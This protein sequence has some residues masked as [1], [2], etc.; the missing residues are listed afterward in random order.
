MKTTL[1][2]LLIA[3]IGLPAYS[4]TTVTTN[5]LD[6]RMPEI[7]YKR[8][9]AAPGMGGYFDSPKM[10]EF[11][12][13]TVSRDFN[14]INCIR[15]LFK[16]GQTDEFYQENGVFKNQQIPK[17]TDIRKYTHDAG[18]EIISQ[19]GG[20]PRNS[21]YA[22]DTTFRK[23]P[24]PTFYEPDVDF[25]PIPAEGESMS[26]FQRNFS[27]WAI[28][29]DKAIGEDFH[30]IWIG[31]QEITHTI[32]FRDG[33]SN[34]TTKQEAI[35]RFVDY[36]KPIS[37]NL[38]AAGART[39]GVQM[40]SG[41]TGLYNYAVDY[42]IQQG[43]QLDFITYQFYQWGDTSD[44]VKAVEALDRYNKVYPEA[45]IIVDRGAGGK[46]LP[47]G[48]TANSS[49]GIASFL[50]GELFAMNHADK[51]Y[52]YTLDQGV[53]NTVSN[54]D[55]DAF[56]VKNW[57]N[58]MGTIRCGLTG[59]PNKMNGFVTRT[60]KKVT[61]AIWNWSNSA[62]SL[63][64]K[65]ENGNF[66]PGTQLTIQH[67][68]GVDMI[69][70]TASWNDTTN[71][72][73]GIEL[74]TFDLVFIDLESPEVL[75]VGIQEN[76]FNEVKIYPNPVGDY[77]QLSNITDKVNIEIYNMQGKLMLRKKV[78][79]EQVNISDISR[80]SYILKI[81]SKNDVLAKAFVKL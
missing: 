25:A 7:I 51:I 43:L 48:V 49:R 78:T 16:D 62:Q 6:N 14:I 77:I 52:A 50:K 33:V 73:E 11:V 29:A 19:V 63:N 15:N 71:T 79:N 26:E 35:R 46:I 54:Y 10:R 69:N 28:N 3:I 8:G 39:G 47:E 42:M 55:D 27:E 74:D 22:F 13:I 70:S 30:S 76:L 21:G 68:H 57:L 1:L 17:F 44:F 32:G 41:T 36:W 24:D 75:R 18:L 9:P 56:N 5:L 34:N 58:N 81:I 38:R 72:I 31:T 20:T 37:D 65:V 2:L 61:A 64:L 66:A 4:Q 23:K 60:D 80:G 53:N 12:D 40:N 45:K 67:I 59:L